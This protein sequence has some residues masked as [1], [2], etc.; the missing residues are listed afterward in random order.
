MPDLESNPIVELRGVSNLVE[1]RD[2]SRWNIPLAVERAQKFAL[3][4]ISAL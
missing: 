1:D 2:L 4:F 3:Q